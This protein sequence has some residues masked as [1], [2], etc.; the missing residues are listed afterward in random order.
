[1]S[2]YFRHMQDVLDEVGVEITP[3][4]KKE[5]DRILHG[6]AGVEYKNCSAAWKKIKEMVKGDASDRELF[7]E[8]LKEAVER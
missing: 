3:G 6:I 2:C 5:I 8:K 4:N 1:M 7:V